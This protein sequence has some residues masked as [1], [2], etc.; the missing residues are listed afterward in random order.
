MARVMEG[1]WWVAGGWFIR[2]SKL[3][4]MGC[5][6]SLLLCQHHLH[7]RCSMTPND[8]PPPPP[9]HCCSTY[10]GVVQRVYAALTGVVVASPLPEAAWY[11][12]AEAALTAIYALHPAPEHLSAAVLRHLARA[13]FVPAADQT[14]EQGEDSV[15]Q[16]DGGSKEGGEEGGEAMEADG[17]PPAEEEPEQEEPEVE[18]G[19]GSVPAASEQTSQG[20]AGSQAPRSMHSVVPLSRFFFALGHVALQH[21]VGLCSVYWAVGEGAMLVGAGRGKEGGGSQQ[22]MCARESSIYLLPQ[23]ALLRSSVPRLGPLPHSPL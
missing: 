2:R 6:G 11:S 13:A 7:T 14:A 23:A 8:P 12:A 1:G 21:L 19:E 16:G 22:A 17:A 15:Q 5:M 3:G 10:D 20:Q 4:C 9:A 18:G